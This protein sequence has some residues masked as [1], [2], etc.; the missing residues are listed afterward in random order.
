MKDLLDRFRLGHNE[1]EN[2]RLDGIEGINPFDLFELWMTEAV[3]TEERE[4]NAFV[5][6]TIDEA[7]KPSSRIVYLKDIIEN[8]FV[9]YTNYNSKKGRGIAANENVSM[10]FFWPAA[11][12]Q[13]R[14]EGTCTKVKEEISDAYFASRPRASQIG[15]WAS[16]QSQ[17]LQDRAE[18]EQRVKD[19]DEKFSGEVPRP[20]HWGGFQIKPEAFEFWQ[21]RPSRLHDR[22]VFTA[23]N[24]QW[25]TIKLNP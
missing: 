22:I 13:I 15:A 17:A 6:S 8:Q 23:D 14:I 10:L 19:F 25:N 5:L 12:R 21:G 16:N 9:L 20:E 18:L 11:S 7:N 3:E 4:A 2:G 24:E 1:F